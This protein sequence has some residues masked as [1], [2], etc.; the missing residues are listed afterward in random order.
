MDL[1][2]IKTKTVIETPGLAAGFFDKPL[3]Q[4][5]EGLQLTLVNLEVGNDGTALVLGSHEL[6]LSA[7]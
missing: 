7:Q 2:P 3:T 1:I 5:L 4:R 6:L